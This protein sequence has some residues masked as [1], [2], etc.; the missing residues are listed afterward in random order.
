MLFKLGVRDVRR[1]PHVRTLLGRR[2]HVDIRLYGE[3]LKGDPEGDRCLP[4]VLERFRAA[5]GAFKRTEDRRF[6]TL[7]ALLEA[8]MRRWGP[9]RLRVHDAGVSDGRTAVALYRRLREFV[10]VEYT[11]SD[12]Y[13]TVFVVRHRRGWSV[14]FDDDGQAVQYAGFGFVLAPPD[15]RRLLLDPLNRLL[16][17]I[18]QT[19]LAP[20]A[21]RALASVDRA[22]LAP[23]MEAPCGAFRVLR[24]PL[25]C[26]A[27]LDLME[28]DPAFRFV[29][30]DVREPL[31]RRYDLVRAMNVLNH[32]RP[33]ERGEAFRALADALEEGGLL[34][35]GRSM[36]PG[37][38]THASVWIREGGRLRHLHDLH[39]GAEVRPA[40]SD[41]PGPAPPEPARRQLIR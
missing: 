41:C 1:L 26:R 4:L 38:E 5:N 23:L 39:G 30:H 17:R 32:L 27:C 3:I 34:A 20:H 19:R 13:P 8:E 36:D 22:A 7:D 37:G 28:H 31:P 9:R 12:W 18:F 10:D 40:V 35:V 21:G 25:V 24:I 16:E 2:K 29:R 15:P 11:A 14:A 6:E 33:A